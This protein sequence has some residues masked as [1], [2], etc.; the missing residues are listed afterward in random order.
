MKFGPLI[1]A[2]LLA[3]ATV[4]IAAGTVNAKPQDNH[5]VSTSGVD[6][7]VA[8][9]TV[10]SDFSRV[11]TTTVDHG[12]FELTDNGGKVSLKSDNGVVI[13]EIPLTYIVSESRMAVAQE[14]SDDGRK[15]TL[16]PKVTAQNIGE[17]QPINSMGR[18]AAEV[19]QNVVGVVVGGLLGGLIGT[20]LGFGFFSIITGPVG[21]VVGA[22]AGGAITGGQSFMDAVTAVV[23]GQP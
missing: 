19:N 10:V 6:H 11:V 1:P 22:I 13:T 4:G 18:L 23:S 14:I 8:Y 20:V 2:T 16:T 9:H 17:M 3:V 5:D 12:K 15:L 21:L 7:G